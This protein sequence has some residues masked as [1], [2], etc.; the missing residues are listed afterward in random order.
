MNIP[1]L[2]HVRTLEV[3]RFFLEKQDIN[4]LEKELGNVNREGFNGEI[5]V[6]Y[7]GIPYE[8]KKDRYLLILEDLLGR[9]TKRP[10]VIPNLLYL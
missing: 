4:W 2:G 7:H 1:D 6:R 8:V 3:T 9:K 10:E 5:V